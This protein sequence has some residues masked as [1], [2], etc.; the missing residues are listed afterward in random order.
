MRVLEDILILTG[1]FIH[2]LLWLQIAAAPTVGGLALG[3]LVSGGSP[4]HP[5]TFACGCL[6]VVLGVFWAEHIR[7]TV[8]LSGFFGRVIAQ[9]QN[10]EKEH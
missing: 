2:A 3:W 9:S 10:S 8:G 5:T 4:N 7:K 1:Y 6:G